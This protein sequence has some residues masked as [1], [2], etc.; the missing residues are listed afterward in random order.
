[1]PIENASSQTAILPCRSVKVPRT[2]NSE[3]QRPS[4]NQS[5]RS[6]STTSPSAAAA[7]I[8]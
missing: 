1:L 7:C 3:R 4:V 6:V 8:V 2:Q 5:V